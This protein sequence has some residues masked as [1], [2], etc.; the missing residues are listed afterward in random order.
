MA[1]PKVVTD[2]TSA[3]EEAVL[4]KFIAAG[5]A[6]KVQVKIWY[7]RVRY[8]GSAWEVVSTTDSAGLTTGALAW[9]TNQLQLTLAN[10]SNPPVILVT[11]AADDDANYNVK[12]YCFRVEPVVTHPA[13]PQTR[14]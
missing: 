7:A 10:W 2:A 14:T 8:T 4:N 9:S 6:N 13:P 11:P 12:A 3:F 1:T 5:E